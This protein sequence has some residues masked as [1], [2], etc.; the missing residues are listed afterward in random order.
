M[1]LFPE[2]D[3]P[4]TKIHSEKRYSPKEWR[5]LSNCDEI[6]TPPYALLPE[7]VA[8]LREFVGDG[9]IWEPCAGQGHLTGYLKEAGFKVV[10]TTL[11]N[12]VREIPAE[13]DCNELKAWDGDFL[14]APNCL[15][16][17]NEIRAIVTNPPF[18]I[19]D[20]IIQEALVFKG[21][22]ALLMPTSR[23]NGVARHEL[24]DRAGYPYVL[25]PNRRINYITPN[26]GKSAQQDTYWFT[27][28]LA[29]AGYKGVKMD[30]KL[31]PMNW[32]REGH[33]SGKSL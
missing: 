25:I 5:T 2:L 27:W 13:W 32:R 24:Y 21:V 23:L 7:L 33:Y 16:C 22:V 4:K 20:K 1:S 8:M 3:S 29:E 12:A 9:Y 28:G 17:R 30:R 31:K 26:N 18:S 11:G 10:S 14:N 6:Y 19:S 15:R